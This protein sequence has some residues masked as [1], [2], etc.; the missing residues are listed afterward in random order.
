MLQRK[1]RQNKREKHNGGVFISQKMVRK[2][3]GELTGVQ[4]PRGNKG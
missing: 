3:L 4:K 2:G 1:T